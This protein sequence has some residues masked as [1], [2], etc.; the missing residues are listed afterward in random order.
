[1]ENWKLVAKH[2]GLS[3]ADI[4]AIQHKSMQDEQLMRLYTLEEWKNK[5]LIYGTATYRVLLEASLRSGCAETATQVCELL[6]R[7]KRRGIN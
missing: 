7:K 3:R 5:N 2:L 6:S 1:M 4:Q